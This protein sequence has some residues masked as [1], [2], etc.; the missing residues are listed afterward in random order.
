LDEKS[1]RKSISGGEK[2][3]EQENKDKGRTVLYLST[4]ISNYYIY[5]T[6]LL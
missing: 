1:K 6:N 2:S 5:P 3:E 4:D